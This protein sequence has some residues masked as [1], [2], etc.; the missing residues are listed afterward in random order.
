MMALTLVI[1]S[2]ALATSFVCGMMVAAARSS[3]KPVS[4]TRVTGIGGIFFR[5]HDS[6]KL[7]DWYRKHLGISFEGEGAVFHP[8][9]WTEKENPSKTGV[10]VW[11]IFP[12]TTKY[13]GEDKSRFMINYR[14]ANLERVMAELKKEGVEVDTKIQDEDNGRFSWATDPEGNRF[15]LWEPK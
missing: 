14:V 5:A 2:T 13:L 10:T 7:A 15:E 8:F 11:A 12:E 6:M 9:E 1:T 4:E 3:A